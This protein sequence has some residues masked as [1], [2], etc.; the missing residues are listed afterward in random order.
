M[1]FPA[2]P[3]VAPRPLTSGGNSKHGNLTCLD[4]FQGFLRRP[5]RRHLR[6]DH[7]FWNKNRAKSSFNQQARF[8]VNFC[9]TVSVAPL[10]IQELRGRRG[11]RFCAI[12]AFVI[13]QL[14]Q[15]LD[16]ASFSGGGSQDHRAVT[17]EATMR[18]DAGR[19]GGIPL[20]RHMVPADSLVDL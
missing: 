8:S 2:A 20:S 10:Q 9:K 17:N 18:C 19:R 14:W 6:D 1:P 4:L 15:G 13:R 12:L 11:G 7:Q 16:A 5:F 3:F